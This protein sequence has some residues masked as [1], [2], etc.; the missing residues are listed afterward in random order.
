MRCSR[1]SDAHT[2]IQISGRGVGGLERYTG[3]VS[4]ENHFHVKGPLPWRILD[5][6][7]DTGFVI[8]YQLKLRRIQDAF[9]VTW[10]LPPENKS[11]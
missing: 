6:W 9:R 8:S 3:S 5:L 1:C 2:C 7:Q 4:K 11:Q 10:N